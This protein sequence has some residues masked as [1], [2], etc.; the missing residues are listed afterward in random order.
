MTKRMSDPPSLLH[1]SFVGAGATLLIAAFATD[2]VYWRTL[3]FQWNNF[4]AWL[5]VAGLILAALAGLALLVDV[6][7]GHIFAMAWG[8]FAGFTA[9]SLLALL[10]AF[11]HSRDAYTAVVPQGLELSA[12]VTV[13]LLILGTRGWSLRGAGRVLISEPEETRP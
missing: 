2:L 4:S 13:I 9:A 7:R 5:L 10:N 8:R 12:L 1:P 6:L 3:L 11:V